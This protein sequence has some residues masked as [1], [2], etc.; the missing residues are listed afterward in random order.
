[1]RKAVEMLSD[2]VRREW[3]A[4]IDDDAFAKPNAVVRVLDFL[5]NSGRADDRS[6]FDG[7]PTERSERAREV[8]RR[9]GEDRQRKG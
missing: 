3:Y 9:I 8:L 5:L 1:M 6:I 2:E 7:A 4:I